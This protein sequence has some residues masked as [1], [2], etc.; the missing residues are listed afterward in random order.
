MK[1]HSVFLGFASLIFFFHSL[2]SVRADVLGNNWVDAL[3][4][5][6]SG[7]YVTVRTDSYGDMSGSI[8][9][10]KTNPVWTQ[11]V[12]SSCVA[13][14][15]VRTVSGV[16][17]VA[18]AC[19]TGAEITSSTIDNWQSKCDAGNSSY[20]SGG[21][22]VKG[23]TY[24][25][26]ANT[27][28]E[29][30]KSHAAYTCYSYS[31]VV[32]VTQDWAADGDGSSPYAVLEVNK[33]STLTFAGA[34]AANLVPVT[35]KGII[36]DIVIKDTTSTNNY[37]SFDGSNGLSGSDAANT[38]GFIF[39]NNSDATFKISDSSEV[40]SLDYLE[41]RNFYRAFDLQN[42]NKV[43]V[44]GF[45]ELRFTGNKVNDT[46]SGGAAIRTQDNSQLNIFEVTGNATFTNNRA[47]GAGG[48]V[49]NAKS[50]FINKNASFV[51][52]ESALYSGTSIT[53]GSHGGGV[54][55][56]GSFLVG[57]SATATGAESIS[58]VANLTL[59]SNR[60]YKDGGGIYNDGSVFVSDNTFNTTGGT[61]KVS[62][63]LIATENTAGI[64]SAGSGGAIY[65]LS[66]GYNKDVGYSSLQFIVTQ[67]GTFSGNTANSGNGGAI[68]NA[69][70]IS[71]GNL[72]TFE[73]N[74]AGNGGGALYNTKTGVSFEGETYYKSGYMVFKNNIS[75]TSNTASSGS[76]GAI[77]NEGLLSV[78]G[79]GTFANS[80][81]GGSGGAIYN[82]GTYGEGS[83]TI[84]GTGTFSN[85]TANSGNGGVLY[86]VGGASFSVGNTATFISN[87]AEAGL[88]GA[89][90]NDA[91]TV[92]LKS[93][94]F[95]QTSSGSSALSGGAIYNTNGGTVTISGNAD[96]VD[97][98]ASSGSGGAIYNTNLIT[99]TGNSSFTNSNS[100]T[101]GGAIYNT[102]TVTISGTGT[103][104]N[105]TANSGSGG[106]IYNAEGASFSVNNTSSFTASKAEAGYGG[107]VYND[108]S[109]LTLTNAS[110]NDSS[111]LS[112]GAVYN[113][114]GGTVNLVVSGA[115]TTFDA[116]RA[117]SSTTNC[118]I[119]GYCLGGAIYNSA[120]S[121][122]SSGNLQATNNLAYLKGGFAYNLGTL[123]LSG[124]TTF[125]GNSAGSSSGGSA[126]NGLGGVFFNAG[127][128]TLGAGTG[129]TMTHT[130]TS[131][132][133][134]NTLESGGAIYNTGSFTLNNTADFTSN[135][136]ASNGGAVYN[137]NE[138]SINTATFSS[139][140]SNAK[141]GAIYNAKTFSIIGNSTFSGNTALDGGALYNIAAGTLILGI[142]GSSTEAM[143]QNNNVGGNGGA[144]YN[145][146]TLTIKGR[147][148][149]LT[150][151][152]N[153]ATGSGG[154]IYNNVTQE[155]VTGLTIDNMEF[156]S[157]K[158]RWG[159]AIY[160]QA[161][162]LVISDGNSQYNTRFSNNGMSSF[163]AGETL[164]GAI[165]NQ[166][167]GNVTI[168]RN[169]EFSG[170]TAGKGMAIY[171]Q[172]TLSIK[173]NVTFTAHQ[174]GSAVIYNESTGK[175]SFI[176][177]GTVTWS[178]NYSNA[179]G[180]GIYNVGQISAVESGSISPVLYF[181]GNSAYQG[182]GGAINN[183]TNGDI[184]LGSV[185][186]DSNIA[187]TSGST[188]A[189]TS[190]GAV[191]NR[192]D[193][194]AK[195]ITASSNVAYG[196]G[197]AVYNALNFSTLSDGSV[198]SS[199][200]ADLSGGAIYNNIGISS[201]SLSLQKTTFASN[202][203]KN[204]NGGAVYNADGKIVFDAEQDLASITS[205]SKQKSLTETIF[206]GNYAA[207]T[208]LEVATAGNG[209]AIY[210]L[211]TV[212]FNKYATFS[213]N[214]AALSGGAIAN[215]GGNLTIAEL[216]TFEN[217]EATA[218]TSKGGAIYNT[219]VKVG[220]TL[221]SGTI[222]I[223]KTTFKNNTSQGA[224][225][226]VYTDSGTVTLGNAL[227]QENAAKNGNGGA[228]YISNSTV[229]LGPGAIFYN[230]SAEMLDQ[231]LT[232]L[233]GAI[234]ITGQKTDD[235]GN[236]VTNGNG[237]PVKGT[238][239]VLNMTTD[240]TGT[241]ILFQGNKASDVS[242]AI[243]MG[244]YSDV[245]FTLNDGGKL[246]LYD[247]IV[248]ASNLDNS[249]NKLDNNKKIT[250]KNTSGDVGSITIGADMSGYTEDVEIAAGT[251]TITSSGVF[252]KGD[253]HVSAS[254][255][256][257]E[258]QNNKID[259]LSVNSLDL[260][261]NQLS[262]NLNIN[263]VTGQIDHFVLPE[264]V[265]SGNGGTLLLTGIKTLGEYYIYDTTKVYYLV[266]DADGNLADSSIK[267]AGV[268]G[269]TVESPIYNYKPVLNADATGIIFER[270][271]GLNTPILR[272][273]SSLIGSYVN[274]QNLYDQ[275]AYLEDKPGLFYKGTLWAK[276][277]M[278]DEDI[279][280][281]GKVTTDDSTGIKDIPEFQV[282]NKMTGVVAG[283][284]VL[285]WVWGDDVDL[286]TSGFIGYASSKQD[287]KENKL[288]LSDYKLT[289][290][291]GGLRGTVYFSRFF[292]SGGALYGK[293]SV[294]MNYEHDVAGE[295]DVNGN[296]VITRRK[297]KVDEFDIQKYTLFA[298]AGVSID[299][300]KYAT[301]QP[302]VAILRTY[303]TP[304]DFDSEASGGKVDFDSFTITE[305]SPEVR[306]TV[307]GD[308]WRP[309]V[310]YKKSINMDREDIVMQIANNPIPESLEIDDYQEYGLG[311]KTGPNNPLSLEASFV[312]RTGGREGWTAY[313]KAIAE[314]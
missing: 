102:K 191:Y 236:F 279:S 297:E 313:L 128:V 301:L 192:A 83:I 90:Y 107:A 183:Y 106:A 41:F 209:G 160:N 195:K 217:N 38:N 202:Q 116:N 72:A 289:E 262:L 67:S 152:S 19:Y 110:F 15:T 97:S 308:V 101:A 26:I 276:P 273:Q 86:N 40:K 131:N 257:F 238:G 243:Y 103:F 241:T 197:G 298:K 18:Q 250:F 260:N 176:A 230:N 264:V 310:T 156:S 133:D 123:S 1:K 174:D 268:D 171:N 214:Q 52:N 22:S 57:Y 244:A 204:G 139:N 130:F 259:S 221:T 49:Q 253:I 59:T 278:T 239:A 104:S 151:S 255:A 277:F 162:N 140:Q 23:V 208:D 29:D 173:N 115:V 304:K 33:G 111:A 105:S 300:G 252:F 47:A 283:F 68:Y 163:T 127:T 234:Y 93:A 309:F 11:D 280:L 178:A 136:A 42:A 24:K 147:G 210:N 7:T 14:G 228:M 98:L 34:G 121:T 203:V 271:P 199:N 281:S 39:N 20:C 205:E 12:S 248:S 215:V 48:A 73:N 92:S 87:K 220:G 284:D 114:N 99:I 164:G 251:F 153:G 223:G 168:G 175:I 247:P 79:T 200:V 194:S 269:L 184:D 177:D 312:H 91:S 120:D 82:N 159:G 5:I 37:I 126:A 122:L 6:M 172:G 54:Y 285:T 51:G 119:S 254:D 146:G 27:C 80:T 275:I 293:S 213:K 198:F 94:T 233:G 182:A 188:S 274:T 8:N 74:I 225:G 196:N 71:F 113:T 77:Y 226:A 292:L 272:Y 145:E 311:V 144:V 299:F 167:Q 143:F 53:G 46:T 85:S 296:T 181:T 193:F 207:S 10:N 43:L 219:S 222:T 229:N 32:P 270:L 232:A 161:G 137:G 84:S 58:S 216:G 227:F 25:K 17:Y 129:T 261:G 100:A 75:F 35:V 302:S 186:F 166:T 290:L 170:N 245:N 187:G 81:S 206:T 65:N 282:K 135:K 69:G 231:T 55:N 258:L 294:S 155:G 125:T 218:D 305:L 240:S 88:G 306:L 158:A 165:Y 4:S 61:V 179:D 70:G 44:T 9:I 89:I 212:Q 303:M 124:S 235:S 150:N 30:D 189:D 149:F 307:N 28:Y 76:G 141:G 2:T 249:G 13:K 134:L 118:S 96:F 142:S 16:N 50:V 185:T 21:S 117:G 157:N 45:G 242:N 66:G 267:I 63:S 246:N 109:T 211:D 62:G 266:Q 256:V 60:A 314:F 263:F 291:M 56:K 265:T 148:T 169:V 190:G 286:V 78:A 138:M 108:A 201:S 288:V 154:A 64:N 36:F 180:G 3:N 132:G 31:I 95:G 287:F 224:G 295:T 112:G 237:A